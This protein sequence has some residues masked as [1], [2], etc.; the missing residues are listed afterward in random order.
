MKSANPPIRV[1][2]ADDHALLREGF[3]SMI[4]KF[5]EIQLV[6]EAADGEELVRLTQRLKPDVVIT[7]VQMP[8]MDGIQAT[9]KIKAEFPEISVIALSIFDEAPLVLDMLNAGALGYLLKSAD[10]NEIVF[11]IKAAY[12]K[13]AYFS[14]EIT[15]ILTRKLKAHSPKPLSKT[16]I[17]IIKLI[18]KQ[19]C[20]K[21]IADE[22][23]LDKSTIDWYRKALL[24]KLNVQNTAGI[25]MYAAK[26]NI[27]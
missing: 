17:E 3:N 8:N 16:E 27:C 9:K 19:Y 6:G 22:L 1:I 26:N 18:C 23:F 14:K 2:I 25:V 24:E 10:K 4:K 12:N 21:Q 7:D 20:S 15:E 11:A 5:K 13:E